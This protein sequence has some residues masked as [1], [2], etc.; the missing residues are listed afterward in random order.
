METVALVIA[1]IIIGLVC[2]VIAPFFTLAFLFFYVKMPIICM[3]CVI[4]GIIN[5]WRR[6]LKLMEW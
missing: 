5:A 4:L 3:L 2:M 6:L 1:W